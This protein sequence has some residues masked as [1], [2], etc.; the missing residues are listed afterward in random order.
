MLFVD[1]ENLTH[2]AEK[3]AEERNMPLKQGA[4]YSP[5]TFI[6]MQGIRPRDARF[7]Q[8]VLD[9]QLNAVRAHYYTSV[10]GSEET[11]AQIENALWAIGFHPE[12]FH[13]QK[14][15][16]SKGVDI[17][18]ASDVLSHAFQDNYDVAFLVAGDGDYVPLVEHI[19]RLGKIVYLAFFLEPSLNLKL[20]LACDMFFDLQHAFDASNGWP[21]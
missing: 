2:E 15:H 20:K 6:W 1:G 4:Y 21:Q 8:G 9:I 5:G 12:V 19:K 14:G 17:T 7:V 11:M 13:K 10:V 18:L 16:R 3:I